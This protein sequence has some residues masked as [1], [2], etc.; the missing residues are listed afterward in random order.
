MQGPASD[1]MSMAETRASEGGIPE[2]GLCSGPREGCMATVLRATLAHL[3]RS[4]SVYVLCVFA[5]GRCGSA[6]LASGRSLLR[7]AARLPPSCPV[8]WSSGFVSGHSRN[9]CTAALDCNRGPLPLG[10]GLP[11]HSS[12]NTPPNLCISPAAPS[13]TRYTPPIE[14]EGGGVWKRGGLLRRLTGLARL[15]DSP[16]ALESRD[17]AAAF[18]SLDWS[19]LACGAVVPMCSA[20]RGA[21]RDP[22]PSHVRSPQPLPTA[23]PMA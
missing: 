7:L 22:H 18:L 3:Y 8:V 2:K 9:G 23:P 20:V 12:S 11:S 15:D 10:K 17:P 13:H 1:P 4:T 19:G 6:I 21:L 16:A 14:G 5:K